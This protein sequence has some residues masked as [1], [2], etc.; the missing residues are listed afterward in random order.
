MSSIILLHGAFRGGWCW[1]D[2]VPL[3]EAAGHDVHAPTLTGSEP[4]LAP[5]DRPEVSLSTWIDDVQRLMSA[6]DL[7]DVVLVGHSQGGVVALATAGADS[8]RVDRLVLLD[9]PVPA[10]GESALEVLPADLRASWGSPPP[11]EAWLDATPVGGPEWV[12]RDELAAWVNERLAPNPARPG[13]DPM[14]LRDP[15]ATSLP[16]TY[17]FFS[18]T[19]AMFPSSVSRAALE[20]AGVPITVVEGGHDLPLLD[21]AACA[22]ALLAVVGHPPSG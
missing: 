1:R 5:A 3:L 4:G 7:R 15:A 17:I 13:Y 2:V 10:Y 6:D 14:E 12:G 20:A 8:S 9:A 22:Q 16:R 21:P 18:R 19:P 11:P